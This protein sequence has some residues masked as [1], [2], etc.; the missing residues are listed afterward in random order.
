MEFSYIPCEAIF[1]CCHICCNFQ[2]F[3]S[4]LDFVVTQSCNKHLRLQSIPGKMVSIGCHKFIN[5]AK[6]IKR[7]DSNRVCDVPEAHSEH[8]SLPGDMSHE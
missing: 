7:S 3:L 8:F 6:G 5:E 1:N 2:Y 4:G